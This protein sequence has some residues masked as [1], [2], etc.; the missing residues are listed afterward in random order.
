MSNGKSDKREINPEV[1][2]LPGFTTLQWLLPKH[3]EVPELY[4]LLMALLLGQQVKELPQSTQ[5]VEYIVIKS[6]KRNVFEYIF[7]RYKIRG[8]SYFLIQR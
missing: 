1:C 6:F 3:A 4:F 7:K 8:E 5:V 2:H